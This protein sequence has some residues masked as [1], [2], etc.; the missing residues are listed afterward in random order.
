MNQFDRLIKYNN[1]VETTPI[2]ITKGY[3]N[4]HAC[5]TATPEFVHH[6]SLPLKKFAT[7][8]ILKFLKPFK[9]STQEYDPWNQ[10]QPEISHANR[11]RLGSYEWSW[12]LDCRS[13]VIPNPLFFFEDIQLCLLL[14]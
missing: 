11:Y 12:K 9:L 4:V 7:V 6:L 3:K 14:H 10:D 2:L 8:S 1:Q 5:N 13:G